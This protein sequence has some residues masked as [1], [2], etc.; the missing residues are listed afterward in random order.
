MATQGYML[1]DVQDDPRFF[2]LSI[3]GCDLQL[4]ASISDGSN[5]FVAIFIIHERTSKV[6]NLFS[7]TCLALYVST[8]TNQ[9]RRI[10]A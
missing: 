8:S 6:A 9:Q 7:R 2:Q 4:H 3:C 1:S 5:P 10:M